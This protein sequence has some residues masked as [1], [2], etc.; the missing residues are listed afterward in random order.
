MQIRRP[1]RFTKRFAKAVEKIEDQRLLNLDLF[2]RT[3]EPSNAAPLPQEYV[4]PQPKAGDQQPKE[5]RWRERGQLL[6][7][8]RVME[9]LL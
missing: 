6:P 8:G 9:V 4:N 2:L 1:D 5:N 3:F 7:R